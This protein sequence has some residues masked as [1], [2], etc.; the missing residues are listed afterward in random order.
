MKMWMAKQ[1]VAIA[2]EMGNM[3]ASSRRSK[4]ASVASSSAF[5]NCPTNWQHAKVKRLSYQNLQK[6]GQKCPHYLIEG[7]DKR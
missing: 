6:W 2:P 5:C 7:D 1:H 4:N 3:Q